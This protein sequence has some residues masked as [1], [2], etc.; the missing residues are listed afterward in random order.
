MHWDL[1][2]E[3]YSNLQ[4]PW[5]SQR[6]QLLWPCWHHFLVTVALDTSR[7]LSITHPGKGWPTRV[8]PACRRLKQEDGEFKASLGYTVW[9]CLRYSCSETKALHPATIKH[10]LCARHC[11]VS[12]AMSKR[13]ESSAPLVRVWNSCVLLVGMEMLLPLWKTVQWFLQKLNIEVSP[14]PAVTLR[15]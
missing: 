11:P 5:R 8:I 3:K 15:V 10:L 12:S 2:F 9:H 4:I 14:D 7:Y 13:L 6:L 1:Q